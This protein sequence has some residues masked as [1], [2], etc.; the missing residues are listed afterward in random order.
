MPPKLSKSPADR[1]ADYLYGKT[2]A[3]LRPEERKTVNNIL[4][5]RTQNW[6][7]KEFQAWL[8]DLTGQP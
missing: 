4:C 5:F 7:A 2:F 3:R 6:T 1:I 8:K